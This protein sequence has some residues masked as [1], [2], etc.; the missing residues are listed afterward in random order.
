MGSRGGLAGVWDG[1]GASFVDDGDMVRSL[2]Y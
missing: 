1:R 2:R